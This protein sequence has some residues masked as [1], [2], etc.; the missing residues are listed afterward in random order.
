MDP[1]TIKNIKELKNEICKKGD[2]FWGDHIILQLLAQKLKI[3]FLII[4]DHN[5][6]SRV[7]FD[8]NKSYNIILY[9]TENSHYQLI[10]EFKNSHIKTYF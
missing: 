1:F 3:N 7:Y 9:Y 10:G 2:N 8:E 4:D 6:M 5:G